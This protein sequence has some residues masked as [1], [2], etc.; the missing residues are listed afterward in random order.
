M[1][2]E[3]SSLERS[4]RQEAETKPSRTSTKRPQYV[5]YKK[6][7]YILSSPTPKDSICFDKLSSH[8]AQL[9]CSSVLH[10]QHAHIF[11]N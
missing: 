9:Q 3:A 6:T 8:A 4:E 1:D 7:E 2:T 10:Q 5:Q 11:S